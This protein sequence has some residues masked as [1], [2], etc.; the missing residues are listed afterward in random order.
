ML[1]G[2][3]GEH[4]DLSGM[5]SQPKQQAGAAAETVTLCDVIEPSWGMAFGDQ[6]SS[7]TLIVAYDGVECCV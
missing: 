5:D 1:A 6:S 4:T 3:A 2:V 7:M